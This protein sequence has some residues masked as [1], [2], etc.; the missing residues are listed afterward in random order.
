[1]KVERNASP[2]ADDFRQRESQKEDDNT[3][4]QQMTVDRV[5]S[6][7][8]RRRE[9][10]KSGNTSLFLKQCHCE[11]EGMVCASGS[12]NNPRCENMYIKLRSS[13]LKNEKDKPVERVNIQDE[14]DLIV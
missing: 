4:G 7:R 8:S 5:L 1:M 2:L 10:R 6:L 11:L 13:C 3:F 9:D 12:L 14:H